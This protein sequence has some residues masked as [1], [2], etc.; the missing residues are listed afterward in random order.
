MWDRFD[1]CRAWYAFASEWHNG[2]WS[3]EY[4]IFGR[5]ARLGFRMGSY[6]GHPLPKH[7]SG[8]NDNARYILAQLIRRAR[9]GWH[10]RAQG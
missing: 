10:P 4:A 1:I 3:P 9:K 8:E 7:E 5:L 2:Q 6:S